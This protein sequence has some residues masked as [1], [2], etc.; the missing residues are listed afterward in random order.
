MQYNGIKYIYMNVQS[1]V[2]T[3][4]F[5]AERTDWVTHKQSCLPF[6]TLLFC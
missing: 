4:Y 6:Q 1:D 2:N 5:D 3:F